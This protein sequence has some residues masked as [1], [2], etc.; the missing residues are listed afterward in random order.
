MEAEIA[1][2]PVVVSQTGFSGEK[3]YEVYVRDASV[4]AETVW[5]AIRGKGAAYGLRVIA[6]AHHRRIAAGILSWGQDMDA[7]T[8]P[9]QVNLGYQIPRKKTADYI[10][11]AELEA[12]ARDHRWRRLSVPAEARRPQ[13]RRAACHRLRAGLLAGSGR[14]GRTGRLRDI[15]LVVP[16]AWDQHRTGLRP[17]GALEGRYAD[18]GGAA[19]D[20][21]RGTPATRSMPRS[22]RFRSGHPSIQAPASSPSPRAAT[23]VIDGKRRG[24]RLGPA[25]HRRCETSPWPSGA[26]RDREPATHLLPR[27]DRRA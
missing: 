25:F 21:H 23:R 18:E 4:N 15:A 13:V 11:K 1:G 5:Y 27:P 8:S 20:V 22:A 24:A 17:L 26:C 14:G 16:R 6:P 10:G 3:G 12:A 19:G 9:F 7:E 2:A